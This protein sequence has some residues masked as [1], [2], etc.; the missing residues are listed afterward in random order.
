MP[1]VLEVERYARLARRTVGRAI[2]G[3]STPD[4]WFLKGGADAGAVRAVA[5][6]ATVSAVRRTGKLLLVDLTGRP[7]LGLRFG[8]TGRLIVDGELGIDGLEYGSSRVEPAWIRFGL[9]FADGGALEIV[10]PR[11]LGGVEIAPDESR[12]GPDAVSLTEAELARALAGGRGPLKARLLDQARVAGLGNLLT[13]ESLW[14]ARLSPTREAGSL[15]PAEV[16]R[17]HA[18][19]HETLGELDGRGGSHTGDL[20]VARRPGAGCPRCGAAVRHDTTGGRSTYWCAP[21][22]AS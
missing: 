20:Q 10:D 1:E 15:D 2:T 14:R 7:T 19:I 11:R 22:A 8:M 16:R 3:V 6:G 4:A 12:L 21:C 13:D 9:R 5:L 18:A 17:L